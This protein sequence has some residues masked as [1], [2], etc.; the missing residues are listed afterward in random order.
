MFGFLW[1]L[2]FWDGPL[3]SYQGLRTYQTKPSKKEYFWAYFWMVVTLLEAILCF[4]TTIL[5]FFFTNKPTSI[6]MLVTGIIGVNI[7]VFLWLVEQFVGGWNRRWDRADKFIVLI[8]SVLTLVFIALLVQ[9]F[10]KAS[11]MWTVAMTIF[12]FL[13]LT[14]FAAD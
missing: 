9:D 10:A 12:F 3:Y 8:I 6:L 2:I 14:C 1:V 13:S 5:P 4:S 11:H 7:P